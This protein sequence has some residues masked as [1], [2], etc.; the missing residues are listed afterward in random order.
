[1]PQA[2]PHGNPE[3]GAWTGAT[4]PQKTGSGFQTEADGKRIVFCRPGLLPFCYLFKHPKGKEA[5]SG[6]KRESATP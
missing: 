1:M 2:M 3:P 6:N 4:E 5:T